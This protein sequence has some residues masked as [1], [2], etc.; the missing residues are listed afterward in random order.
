MTWREDK[1]RIDF[2]E[3]TL[4]ELPDGRCHAVVILAWPGGGKHVASAQGEN[5]EAGRFQCAAEATARALELSVAAHDDLKIDVLSIRLLQEAETN[6]VLVLLS[7]RLLGGIRQKLVGS[8]LVK[9]RQPVRSIVYA[10]LKAT[11]RIIGNL[12]SPP[13]Y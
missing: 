12:V 1:D 8:C 10:V 13:E 7:Y 2:G 6:L 9:E 3:L 5:T 4:E 11:N